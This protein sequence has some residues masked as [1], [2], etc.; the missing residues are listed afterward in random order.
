M[1]LPGRLAIENENFNQLGKSLKDFSS[2][3]NGT[4]QAGLEMRTHQKMYNGMLDSYIKVAHV[5]SFR[6]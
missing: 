6:E 3:N 4:F 1:N 2:Y 5:H